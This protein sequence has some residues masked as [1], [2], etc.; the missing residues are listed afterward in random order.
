MSALDF[1]ECRVR[2][3]SKCHSDRCE[4]YAGGG[5]GSGGY[6][7]Q[8]G[9]G[10]GYDSYGGGGYG[11]QA[12]KRG[13]CEDLRLIRTMTSDF[14]FI[15]IVAD[16]LVNLRCWSSFICILMLKHKLFL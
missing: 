11:G 4:L 8:G 3:E 12:G 15:C 1:L 14:F 6:G 2:T 5:Y 7:S 13:F 9:Y 16:C 10:G